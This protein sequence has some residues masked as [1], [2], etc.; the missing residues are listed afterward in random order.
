LSAADETEIPTTPVI[1]IANRLGSPQV[2]AEEDLKIVLEIFDIYK[3]TFGSYPAG[4]ENRHFTNALTGRN[5]ERSAFIA[6][7]H[8]SIGA[9]GDL[10]DRWGRPYRIH[11]VA[12][13]LIEIRSAGPDRE[14]AT[15]DDLEIASPA[16]RAAKRMKPPGQQSDAVAR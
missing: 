14:F 16:L 13:D 5:P 3:R 9:N 7:H 15:G 1:P 8:P 12:R 10:R 2:S 6:P 11:L 4:E